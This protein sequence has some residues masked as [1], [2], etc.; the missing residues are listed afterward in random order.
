MLDFTNQGP[1]VQVWVKVGVR[2][3][4]TLI[5][6]TTCAPQLTQGEGCTNHFKTEWGFRFDWFE[7]NKG[8]LEMNFLIGA[9]ICVPRLRWQTFSGEK[10]YAF[11]TRLYKGEAL[12]CLE[13]IDLYKTILKKK[14][15]KI[16]QMLTIKLWFIWR[17][18]CRSGRVI[19][20]EQIENDRCL[21][22]ML[23]ERKLVLEMTS[24]E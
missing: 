13:W 6:I 7:R 5:A 14:F 18:M 9:K 21:K 16:H 24:W 8:N 2:G 17:I 12:L 15:I 3:L 11:S 19:F 22:F 23:T 10:W 20:T 1:C 4:F